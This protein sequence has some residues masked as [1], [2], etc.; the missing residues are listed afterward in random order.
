MSKLNVHISN[1]NNKKGNAQQILN[2]K[3]KKPVGMQKSML[4]KRSLMNGSDVCL[5]DN[6]T[7]AKFD[8]RKKCLTF[9]EWM[10]DVNRV[11]VE[12][13]GTIKQF[14]NTK[15]AKENLSFIIGYGKHASTDN[16]SDYLVDSNYA[17]MY[18][19]GVASHIAGNIA[20]KQNFH[21]WCEIVSDCMFRKYNVFIKDI[22]RLCNHDNILEFHFNS[23]HNWKYT[24]ETIAKEYFFDNMYG[25]KNFFYWMH[26]INTKVWSKISK[27]VND[28]G[29]AGRVFFVDYVEKYYENCDI[30]SLCE[31]ITATYIWINAINKTVHEKCGKE[32][33]SVK[34][35]DFAGDYCLGKRPIDVANFIVALEEFTTKTLDLTTNKA[36]FKDWLKHVDN[37]V[38]SNIGYHLTDLPDEDFILNYEHGISVR[39]MVRIVVDNFKSDFWFLDY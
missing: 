15:Y 37:C 8:K 27:H 17:D 4:G 16:L 21:I 13:F 31:N 18:S 39:E 30:D 24:V 6:R 38:Y 7:Y 11:F 9:K 34:Y 2:I 14:L 25:C 26:T 10:T 23:G 36:V 1:T 12:R 28:L 5:I 19:E 35:F 3:N 29:F 32:L 22:F 33:Y 20:T